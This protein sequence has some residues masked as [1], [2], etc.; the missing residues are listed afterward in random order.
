VKIDRNYNSDEELLRNF[1][2]P[3]LGCLHST[4][5]MFEFS[6]EMIGESFDSVSNISS[7]S[8]YSNH[9]SLDNEIF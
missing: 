5:S 2:V 1:V 9:S 3:K 4:K 7:P 8:M 6:E